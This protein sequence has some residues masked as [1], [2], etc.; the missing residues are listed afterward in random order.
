MKIKQI[1]AS[2]LA[3][4]ILLTSGVVFAAA[5][6]NSPNPA[7]V[8]QQKAQKFQEKAQQREQLKQKITTIKEDRQRILELK[9]EGKDKMTQ[10]RAKVKALKKDSSALTEEKIAEIK[11]KLS[12]I[13]DDKVEMAQTFGLIQEQKLDMR[14]HKQKKDFP[15]ALANLDTIITVQQKQINTIEKLNTDIDSLLQSL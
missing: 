9:K 10:I 6:P 14:L 12:L 2:I 1:I 3:A 13:R 15:A 11:E 7:G 8:R 5:D 4:G